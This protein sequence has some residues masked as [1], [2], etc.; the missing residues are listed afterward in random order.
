MSKFIELKLND[1]QSAILNVDQIASVIEIEDVGLAV[2][3]TVGEPIYPEMSYDEL[4]DLLVEKKPAT[5]IK[6]VRVN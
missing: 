3:L 5:Y 2:T 1:E 4:K 6:N